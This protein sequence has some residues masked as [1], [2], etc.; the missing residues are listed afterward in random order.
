MGRTRVI[1]EETSLEPKKRKQKPAIT[2]EGREKQMIAMAYDLAEERLRNGTASAQEIVHFL[3]LGSSNNE[4]EKDILRSKS[5]K[6]EAEVDQIQSQKRIEDL[7]ANAISA[8]RS[9]GM[10]TGD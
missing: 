4:L 8:M 1:R 7:Y 6:M 5:R 9:Y 2:P 10:P 3:R